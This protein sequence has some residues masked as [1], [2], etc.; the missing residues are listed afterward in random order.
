MDGV[1]MNTWSAMLIDSDRL[2]CAGLR[3]LLENHGFHVIR[4]CGGLAEAVS[5]VRQ[6][7]SADLVLLCMQGGTA[8]ELAQLKRLRGLAQDARIVVMAT[9]P[10]AQS[11]S[12]ALQAGAD[13]LLDK[14]MSAE[15]LHRALHLVML[16]EAVF[17]STVTELLTG[18]GVDLSMAVRAMPASNDL[19]KREIQILRCLLGGQSNKVI[20]RNLNITESTVKMHF[21]NV[22]RKINAQNRTQAAVW[23]IQHGIAP[24]AGAGS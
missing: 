16:D 21:K 12:W 2:F 3:A 7:G 17:P 8:E 10:K 4:E 6:Q 13:G 11:L 9:D 14:S 15:A 22:M 5:A 1:G 20:A 19:S 23:A 24:S 18:N